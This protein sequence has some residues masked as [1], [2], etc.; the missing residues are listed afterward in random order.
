MNH[1]TP[2]QIKQV[3]ATLRAAVERY[4]GIHLDMEEVSVRGFLGYSIVLCHGG[5]YA[6]MKSYLKKGNIDYRD[7]ANL[8]AN[9]LGFKDRFELQ[10]WA[11]LYKKEWGN[12][13]GFSMF[14]LHSAF[15]HPTKRP[16]GAEHVLHIADHWDEIADRVEAIEKLNQ[17]T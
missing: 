9:D 5:V 15:Y 12:D 6:I 8:I 11:E 4:P 1:P 2:H 14:A 10:F 3:A 16:N 7:G 13:L 17:T